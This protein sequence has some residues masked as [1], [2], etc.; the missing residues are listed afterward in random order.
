MIRIA[1]VLVL[2]L[3]CL[4]AGWSATALAQG[5]PPWDW[6]VIET[7]HFRIL[8]HQGVAELAQEAAAVAEDAYDRWQKE[9][10]SSVPGKINLTVIDNDDSPNGFADTQDLTV[11]AFASQ[12]Q[13]GALFGGQVPSNMGD[14]IYHEFWH[15]NDIDKVYGIS[16]YLRALFGRII[17]PGDTKPGFS[18]EGSAVYSEYL[19]Y[20]Y[21]RATFPWS[22]IYLRQM[23]LDNSFPPLDRLG[24]RFSTTT[25]PGIGVSW[26]TIGGWFM[27]YIE[28]TYGKGTMAKIDEVLGN[29]PLA[30]LSD[31][32]AGLLQD[33]FGAA[34]YLSP[35]F[36]AVLQKATGIPAEKLYADFQGW[37]RQ[38]F[39]EQITNAQREGLTTSRKLSPLTHYNAQPSWSPKGDWLAYEHSDPWRTSG[40]R[41]IRPTGQDDHAAFSAS[42][43]FD[44]AFSWS[45][46][47]AQIVYSNYDTYQYYLTQNDLYLYDLKTRQTRRLTYGQRAFN[48]VFTP[49][50]Q[51]IL[52]A[53]QRVQHDA[54]R[55]PD[56]AQLDVQT[57]KVT[58]I[59]EFPDDTF[60]DFFALS[61]D[62]KTLALSIWKRPG[63][64][65]IYTMPT[66]G[67]DLTPLTQD[68]PEDSHPSWS[69]DGEYILFDS[70]RA[71]IINVYALK[72]SDG[73]LY[74][75]TNVTSAAF[76]PQVSPDGKELAFVSYGSQG[77]SIQLMPYDPSQWKPFNATKEAIPAW[78]GIPKTNYPIHDYSAL[79][80]LS[81]QYWV[82]VLSTNASAVLSKLLFQQKLEPFTVSEIG[83]DT[84]ATDALYQRDYELR[85]GW[86]LERKA[87]FYDFTY[88]DQRLLPPFTLS[89]GLGMD[90][91][92]QYQSLGATYPLVSLTDLSQQLSLN[93]TQASYDKSLTH[94]L[95][96]TWD[97]FYRSGLDLIS[98][99]LRLTVDAS[100]THVMETNEIS[101]E[102]VVNARDTLRLPIVDSQGLH[103]LAVRTAFGW[104]DS[105]SN[106]GLGGNSG[107]FM[108]RGFPRSTLRGKEIVSASAEYRFPVWAIE[109]G[110]GLWP[111]FLDDLRA[112]VFVD[113]GTA[114]DTKLDPS[115]LK[116]S[117]GA[118]LYAVLVTG[119]GSST[120]FRFGIAQGVGEKQPLLYLG[121]G[122]PF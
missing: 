79:A 47:G 28:A 27:R 101:Q 106:F 109:H 38:Q 58:V 110:W 96:G 93:L 14:T 36:G 51:H 98:N 9:L 94:T 17:L 33:N 20:G 95:D 3:I 18:I 69:P 41:L 59:K 53:R 80:T 37:L 99:T 77:F 16:K 1:A 67:G 122:M 105:P 25:Y 48:P 54:D 104:S 26:Y 115:Q 119:Y 70:M 91:D 11:W 63:Y 5:A 19:A 60:V 34:L 66:G 23:A 97:L 8:F 55:S 49:D 73:S 114:S 92:G 120:T 118:E 83:L 50:G 46:D 21:S 24:V 85:G 90:P 72:V 71:P 112:S 86:N 62:G 103:Y 43:I 121:L 113:A 42:F 108:L 82:P 65:D 81:P 78:A 39:D 111:I 76:N 10:K 13:F 52:F 88:N 68:K 12:V 32:L 45:P 15:I 29:D 30:A 40:V 84:S 100:A 107:S 89:L 44:G 61:P 2:G 74:R 64:S 87:L 4:L 56:L 116:L 22:A 7:P 31:M 75:V 57:G 117:F 6:K 35:D 102:Y